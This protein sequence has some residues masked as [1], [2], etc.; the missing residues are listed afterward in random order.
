[1]RYVWTADVR[2][3]RMREQDVDDDEAMHLAEEKAWWQKRR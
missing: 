1:M 3:R 2:E